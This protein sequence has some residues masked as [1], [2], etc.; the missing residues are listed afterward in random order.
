VTTSVDAVPE[1]HCGA[2]QAR[3]ATLAAACTLA[4]RVETEV[5]KLD[6]RVF[7]DSPRGKSANDAA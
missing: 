2:G 3:A 7:G 6:R 4:L 1:I 5:R